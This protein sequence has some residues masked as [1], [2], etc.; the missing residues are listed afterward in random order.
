MAIEQFLQ[1]ATLG[2]FAK[3]LRLLSTFERHVQAEVRALQYHLVTSADPFSW[4]SLS[5]CVQIPHRI[6]FCALVLCRRVP[7][8]EATSGAL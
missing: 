2:E 6:A 3:R 7:A 1:S 5:K 4:S 8:G